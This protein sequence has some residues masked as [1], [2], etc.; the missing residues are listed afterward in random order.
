MSRDGIEGALK[1]AIAHIEHMAAF[2]GKQNAG[3][4]F[5]SLGEDM[6]GIREALTHVK[7]DC[8][9]P[10]DIERQAQIVADLIPIGVEDGQ[11]GALANYVRGCERAAE[12]RI[13]REHAALI[14]DYYRC[15]IGR[16]MQQAQHWHEEGKHPLAVHHRVM[17]A[18]SYFQIVVLFERMDQHGQNPFETMRREL[19]YPFT[20]KDLS[21]YPPSAEIHAYRDVKH[22]AKLLAELEGAAA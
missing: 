17:G 15:A 2:I 16:K 14:V 11:A 8:L 10:S 21:T 4:S 13:E 1:T 5:E 20:R 18:D 3:Y 19:N 7:R 6:P 22:V 9:S 12:A